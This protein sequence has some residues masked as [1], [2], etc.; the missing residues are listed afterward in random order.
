MHNRDL[1]RQLDGYGLTTASILYHMPDYPGL[2]QTYVWQHYDLA[3]EF[4]ELNKFLSFWT[5]SLD[6]PLHSVRV[7]HK[8]LVS[9]AELRAVGDLYTLH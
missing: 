9:P 2:L 5:K 7:A 4:P 1:H 6:G 8:G 3:P